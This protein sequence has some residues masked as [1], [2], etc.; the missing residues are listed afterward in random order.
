MSRGIPKYRLHK[1]TGQGVVVIQGQSHYLGK[2]G[3]KVGRAR[4][5]EIIADYLAN[6]RKLPPVASQDV[7]SCQELAVR[8][9][10]WA[11]GYYVDDG[12]PTSTF[13]RCKLALQPFTRYFGKEP[14]VKFVPESLVFL[15]KYLVKQGIGRETINKR[16]CIIKQCFNWGVTFGHVEAIVSHALQAVPGLKK[17]RTPAPE[18]RDVPP[19]PDEFIEAILPF[20]PPIVADMVRIQRLIGGRPQDVYNMRVCD[21][22]T[23]GEIWRYEVDKHKGDYRDHLRVLP[24]GPRAQAILMPYLIDKEDTPKAFLFSPKDSMALYYSEKRKNRKTK[25]QPSQKNRKKGSGKR[26]PGEH[27]TKDSYNQAVQKACKKA[28]VEP[29][30]PNQIR[31]TAGTVIRERYGLEGVQVHLGHKHAKTSEIYAETNYEKAVQIA[32]ECG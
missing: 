24:I 11:E 32:K 4:G 26:A 3:T 1:A 6:G 2:Y 5:D 23:S 10:E 21:I 14:V 15:Q 7:I 17:G 31:H 19:V 30:S 16:I 22:E 28:G 12:Q 8:F 27:Y 18:Y 9:L 13:R 25:V 29:W 20:L